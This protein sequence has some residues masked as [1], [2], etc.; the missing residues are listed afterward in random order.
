MNKAARPTVTNNRLRWLSGAGLALAE[1][2][3]VISFSI[4]RHIKGRVGEDIVLALSQRH[5]G[6][7]AIWQRFATE[8]LLVTKRYQ[9]GWRRR[10]TVDKSHP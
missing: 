9:I 10:K 8:A 2:L 6:R 3:S 7:H 5:V 4:L 1:T